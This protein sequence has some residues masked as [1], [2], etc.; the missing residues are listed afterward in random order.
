[1]LKRITSAPLLLLLGSCAVPATGGRPAQTAAQVAGRVALDVTKCV[2]GGGAVGHLADGL[3]AYIDRDRDWRRG[4]VSGLASDLGPALA[5]AL[6]QL[7]TVRTQAGPE[8]GGDLIARRAA[9]CPG[10]ACA[11]P[12]AR[13]AWL[14]RQLSRPAAERDPALRGAVGVR[15]PPSGQG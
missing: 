15:L 8:S 4:L 10:G 3:A 5:C 9:G 7:A 6:S 11:D 1:M 2:V 12:A 14:L 13:A